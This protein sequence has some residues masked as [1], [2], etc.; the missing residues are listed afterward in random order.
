MFYSLVLPTETA[1]FFSGIS[2]YF[3]LK[4]LT[5]TSSTVMTYSVSLFGIWKEAYWSVI[6][7]VSS[8]ALLVNG[9]DLVGLT[10]RQEVAKGG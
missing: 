4:D 7:S 8:P 9:S 5:S 1:E 10:H 3:D 6:E 2:K